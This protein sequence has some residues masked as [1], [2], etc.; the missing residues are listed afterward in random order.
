[1]TTQLVKPT[2]MP[3]RYPCVIY[4]SSK[5]YAFDCLRK[6]EVQNMFRTKPTTTT[7]IVTKNPKPDHVPINVVVVVMIHSQVLEQQ[8]LGK[9]ELVKAKT[10]VDW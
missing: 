9:H 6:A 8:V 7:T 1:M 10:T 3:L 5:H 4:F 2:K